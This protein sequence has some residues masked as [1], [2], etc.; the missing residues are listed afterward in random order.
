MNLARYTLSPFACCCIT[1]LAA[2]PT[3]AAEPADQNNAAPV[4]ASTCP[5][6]Q[7]A[8]DGG[9]HEQRV[10]PAVREA[11]DKSADRRAFVV[12][13]LELDHPPGPTEPATKD[14]I[15]L[16]QERF[17]NAMPARDWEL[18]YRFSNAPL[19]VGYVNTNALAAALRQPIAASIELSKVEPPVFEEMAKSSGDKTV[20]NIVLTRVDETPRDLLAHKTAIRAKQNRV[21]AKF[22]PHELTVVDRLDMLEF[23]RV[24]ISPEAVA[25]LLDDPDVSAAGVDAFLRKQSRHA[26]RVGESGSEPGPFLYNNDGMNYVLITVGHESEESN[27]ETGLLA[28][29]TESLLERVIGG[30]PS[31]DLVVKRLLTTRPGVFAYAN[32]SGMER[33]AC[34]R[35]LVDVIPSLIEP[36]VHE[37]LACSTDG[38]V[39]VIVLLHDVGH[40]DLLLTE[41]DRL[42]AP[43]RARL[44]DRLSS[45]GFQD[46]CILEGLEVILGRADVGLL[47]ELAFDP[48]VRGVGYNAPAFLIQ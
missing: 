27:A 1:L 45:L 41:R 29:D 48:D 33:L 10:N 24:R 16:T 20:V 46:G 23:L 11:I 21:L 17:I 7:P 38:F 22:A 9:Q 12:I 39:D 4:L 42:I 34:Y 25:K 32:S 8:A 19:L 40:H 37:V 43:A 47:E 14:Q 2:V 15:R 26:C 36:H 35:D 3:V 44:L 6:T 5:S 31:T 28:S 18:A 30:V 13:T